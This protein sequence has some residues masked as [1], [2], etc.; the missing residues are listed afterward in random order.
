L[1]K[2]QAV[3]YVPTSMD[4]RARILETRVEDLTREIVRTINEA[5]VPG[6]PEIRAELKDFAVELLAD[7]VATAPAPAVIAPAAAA[8]APFNLIGMSI[9]LVFA[10]VVL[11]FLFPPVGL[12][13]FAASALMVVWGLV[14]MVV[15]R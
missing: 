4:E 15:R 10:G 1:T 13:L 3:S 9:P 7:G 6:R 8:P 2:I 11:L 5:E 12:A 14:G